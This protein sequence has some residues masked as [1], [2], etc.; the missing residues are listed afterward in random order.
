MQVLAADLVEIGGQRRPVACYSGVAA[1]RGVSRLVGRGAVRRRITFLAVAAAA[2]LLCS[3]TG[4]AAV[5]KV[6]G[7]RRRA[8]HR[9][10]KANIE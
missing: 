2:R 5:L 4:S 10:R 1:V 7:Q 6:G 3:A 8:Q 9:R